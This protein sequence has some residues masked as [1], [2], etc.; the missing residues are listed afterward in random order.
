MMDKAVKIDRFMKATEAIFN[1]GV[2]LMHRLVPQEKPSEIW[3]HYPPGDTTNGEAQSRYFYHCHPPGQREEGEHGHF[4]LFLGKSAMPVE[5]KPWLSPP[6]I[7]L[8]KKRANV[9]HVA[10]LSIDTNGLPM[11]WFNVNRWVT[12]EWMYSAED[13]IAQLDRFDMVGEQ[14][15]ALVNEWVTAIVHLCKEEIVSLLYERDAV[16]AAQDPSG[17]DHAIEVTG[18]RKID[19]AALVD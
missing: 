19:L 2:P 4:H 15:D 17:Q 1:A 3:A 7:N 14:G 13:V 10:A 8:T 18:S 12:D 6:P 16:L 5:A 11:M 9:V